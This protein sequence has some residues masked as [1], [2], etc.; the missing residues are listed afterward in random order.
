[1]S[2]RTLIVNGPLR[3]WPFRNNCLGYA[4]YPKTLTGLKLLPM[5]WQ[6]CKIPTNWPKITFN[7]LVANCLSRKCNLTTDYFICLNDIVLQKRAMKSNSEIQ[8]WASQHLST[9]V[10]VLC[11]FFETTISTAL[12]FQRLWRAACVA[13]YCTEKRFEGLTSNGCTFFYW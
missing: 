4:T 12:R 2:A 11:V 6:T 10:I 8:Y 7:T 1:M 5:S 13:S 9:F 3:R